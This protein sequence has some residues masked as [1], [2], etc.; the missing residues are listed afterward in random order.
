MIRL[1]RNIADFCDVP[2]AIW[3]DNPLRELA[4]PLIY[5]LSSGFW[6]FRI[7]AARRKPMA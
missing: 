6:S 3:G 5:E 1:R 7:W 2:A 4:F